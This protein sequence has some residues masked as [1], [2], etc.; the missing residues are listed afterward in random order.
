MATS[1]IKEITFR[2]SEVIKMP[3]LKNNFF[4]G[5]LFR[6]ESCSCDCVEDIHHI[7]KNEQPLR[8]YMLQAVPSEKKLFAYAAQHGLVRIAKNG[9]IEESNILGRLI[10]LPDK[11]F[12]ELVSFMSDNGFL[13]PVS[14]TNYEAFDAGSLYNLIERIKN[15]VELMTA[16]SE[17]KKDYTRI[18]QLL[19]SLLFAPDFT[20]KTQS[21]NVVYHCCHHSYR[22]LLLNSD[23]ELSDSRRQEA[24]DNDYFTI[25]D[26]V[27]SDYKFSVEDYNDIVSG[28]STK[29][30]YTESLFQ[31][32]TALY[33]NHNGKYSERRITDFLFHYF[34]D[35]G[36]V[37]NDLTFCSK[38]DYSKLTAEL[39]HAMIDTAKIIIGE[40]INANLAGIH[41]IY[42]VNK[43]SPSWKVD[44][45]LCAVYFSIFY[46]NPELE[47]YR[48]CQNPRCGKYFLVKTT[49]TRV[50]YCSAACCNR[51]T[52]DRYRKRK[53]EREG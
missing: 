17:I 51:V 3:E 52:Q 21:M 5:I 41:P 29:P 25:T 22:D 45:L 44:S 16:I 12:K 38:P 4:E 9:T 28:Y 32:I 19:M 35:I 49:S 46:L 7:S 13:F 40:E 43:M 53:R 50:R 24:F 47:L 1:L 18:F 10:S 30:G 6:Y 26:S 34:Y 20:V 31:K 33:M 14:E 42:D 11:P 36:V 23:I 27:Y 37:T 2:K 15:T 8:S 39:K 48:P